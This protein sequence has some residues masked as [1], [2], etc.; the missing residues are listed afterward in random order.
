[1]VCSVCGFHGNNWKSLNHKSVWIWIETQVHYKLVGNVLK[2][3]G[4]IKFDV[5]YHNS[6]FYYYQISTMHVYL[7][8]RKCTR[9]C[10][11]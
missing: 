7:N 10:F 6:K 5:K 1:M 4:N 2:D 11:Y 3:Q 8:H 9:T